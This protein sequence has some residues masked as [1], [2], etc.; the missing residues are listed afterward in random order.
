M[1]VS[2]DRGPRGVCSIMAERCISRYQPPSGCGSSP[3]R[4]TIRGAVGIGKLMISWAYARRNLRQIATWVTPMREPRLSHDS[5]TQAG[6]R[7]RGP[8]VLLVAARI[9][10]PYVVK[11]FANRRLAAL[12]AYD[13]HVGDI[14]I[15]L[16]RGAYSID[17]I[18]I[19]KTGAS[20]RCRSSRRAASI[21]PWNG[22]AC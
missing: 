11:D 3:S 14:D 22:A 20:G 10:L 21:C 15:H 2:A 8:G 7:A 9:A 18:V 1:E 13:G 4:A 6:H 5:Q 12:E 19:V 16:W 17:D